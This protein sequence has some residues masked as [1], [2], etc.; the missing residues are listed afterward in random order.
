M[1]L[2]RYTRI[3]VV[4]GGLSPER[5]VSLDSGTRVTDALVKGGYTA[6]TPIDMGRDIDVVLRDIRPEVVFNALHGAY[7]EDGR[8]PGLLDI[9]GIP[10]TGSGVTASAVAMDKILTKRV[11]RTLGIPL[12]ADMVV[13]AVPGLAAPMPCPFVFKDPLNGSSHGVFIVRDEA[14][15]TGALAKSI[16]KRMLVEEY[17]KGREITVAVFGDTVL[18]D[19][20]IVPAQE[21]YDYKAKYF[22]ENTRYIPDPDYDPA[23]R[24]AMRREALELHRTL[25]CRGATR[26]DF[27][28]APDR[29][30]MLE[31]NTHPGMT[32]HSL[33]PMAA[34]RRG[35]E[36]LGLIERL[37]TEALAA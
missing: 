29:H 28:V 2:T 3:A 36:Y 8:L 6:V 13:T 26:S 14:E 23:M 19:V 30:I 24:E 5:D 17:V 31:I 34:A 9:I 15:W 20:E 32:G 35:I 1:I 22:D 25:G 18:G 21:F 12:A 27:L 4:M 37:L 7:G 16:G 11:A 10:Y 33:V